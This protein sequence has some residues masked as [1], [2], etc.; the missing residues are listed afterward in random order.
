MT[1]VFMEDLAEARRSAGVAGAIR[2]WFCAAW[3]V[4]RIALPRQLENPA[5]GVPFLSFVQSVVA[6]TAE[7]M[8][9]HGRLSVGVVLLPGVISALTS[10]AAVRAGKLGLPAPLEL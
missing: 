10:I 4:A 5:I 3:E 2:V 7:L 1:E 9:S 6:L 8:L